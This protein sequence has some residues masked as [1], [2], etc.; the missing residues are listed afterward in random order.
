MDFFSNILLGFQVTL[1]PAN[2]LLC[3][4]GVVVGTLVGVL[5]GI[6]PIGAIALLLP[7]VIQASPIYAD[8]YGRH[9]LRSAIWRIDHVNSGKHSRRGIFGSHLY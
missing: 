2:L 9:F 6:G 3:A 8:C 4:I 1:Q 5:P 7:A